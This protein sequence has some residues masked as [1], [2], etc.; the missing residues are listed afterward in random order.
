[1]YRTVS[2]LLALSVV[3]GIIGCDDDSSSNG[4][5]G[6]VAFAKSLNENYEP[7]DETNRFPTDAE[8]I[9]LSVVLKGRPRSGHLKAVFRRNGEE[10][11]S[12]VYDL[13]KTNGG[14][15]ASI[16]QDTV[17]GFTLTPTKPFPIGDRYDAVLY[18]DREELG[19]IQ[20][21]IVA[22]E[23]ASPSRIAKTALVAG[24]R[25][26]ST[27]FGVTDEIAL[28]GR[29][30]FGKHTWIQAEWYVAGKRDEKATRTLTFQKNV[31][32]QEFRFSLVPKGGWPRGRH[33]V[34]L[35]MNDQQL[36]TREFT[37]E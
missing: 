15:I 3:A 28:V 29:G 18:L 19:K 36:A 7:V 1:M 24:D 6:K 5:L 2:S 32:A 10:I 17:V 31:S 11:T 35:T 4:R 37:V 33:R 34:V 27:T 30:D 14:V 13:S 12:V 21:K 9:C 23:G 26:E 25:N 20:F 16:G 22:P 8:K